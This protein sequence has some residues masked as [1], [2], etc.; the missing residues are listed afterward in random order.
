ML[1]IQFCPVITAQ[2]LRHFPTSIFNLSSIEVSKME[3][4]QKDAT[5]RAFS[6]SNSAIRFN[7]ASRLLRQ[8]IFRRSTLRPRS[9][10]VARKS[11]VGSAML[12][13]APMFTCAAGDNPEMNEG[14]LECSSQSEEWGPPLLPEDPYGI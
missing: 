1:Q 11:A 12:L 3:R 14:V 5:Y 8:A 10:Q 6:S 7:L 4:S 13:T 2:I 9:A